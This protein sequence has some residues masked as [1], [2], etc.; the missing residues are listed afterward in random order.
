MSTVSR[1][2]AAPAAAPAATVK[3]AKLNLSHVS[4]ALKD[5]E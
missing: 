5:W 1:H 4:E 3:A 2:Q